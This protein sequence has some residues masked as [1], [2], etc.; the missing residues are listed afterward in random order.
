MYI[1]IQTLVLL[2]CDTC[3]RSATMGLECCGLSFQTHSDRPKVIR[4]H[5][6]IM[7]SIIIDVRVDTVWQYLQLSTGV[8]VNDLLAFMHGHLCEDFFLQ[9]WPSVIWRAYSWFQSHTYIIADPY[10]THRIRRLG[11]TKRHG[12][13]WK[14]CIFLKHSHQIV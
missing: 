4:L 5:M 7:L 10:S 12:V 8:T 9:R 14:K 11:L 13:A 3:I 1:I 2:H 6:F